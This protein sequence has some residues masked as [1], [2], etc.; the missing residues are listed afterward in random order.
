VIGRPAPKPSAHDRALRLLARRDRSEQELR[1]ALLRGGAS[2][3][4]V[5]TALE[6]LRRRGYLDDERYAERFARTGLAVRGLGRHRLRA[7]LVRRG[8]SRPL[9]EHGLAEALYEVSEA[10]VIESLAQ[11][12]W[13]LHLRDE[14]ERRVQKLW[15]FLLRRGFPSDLVRA[16]LEHLWPRSRRAL[17]GL[18]IDDEGSLHLAAHCPP[19]GP[20]RPARGRKP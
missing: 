2:R 17:E 4:E 7:E 5:E 11:K 20:G 1:S 8:V 6:R 14:P 10:E 13:R 3:E 12:Y 19:S 16:R 18:E 9:V 15:A